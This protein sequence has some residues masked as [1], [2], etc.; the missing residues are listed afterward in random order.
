MLKTLLIN[1]GLSFFP[2]EPTPQLQ[3]SQKERPTWHFGYSAQRDSPRIVSLNN[4]FFDSFYVADGLG[5]DNLKVLEG[6]EYL[7]KGNPDASLIFISHSMGEE[8]SYDLE[9]SNGIIFQR[10]SDVANDECV[11]V[12]RMSGDFQIATITNSQI[13]LLKS[14]PND[15]IEHIEQYGCVVVERRDG[16]A[17]I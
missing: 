16:P 8:H 15:V 4:H 14:L 10:N 2:V 17:P 11:F 1:I 5:S 13:I 12:S 7:N 9:Q 6:N 3:P